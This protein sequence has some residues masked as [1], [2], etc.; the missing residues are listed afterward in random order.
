M[1]NRWVVTAAHCVASSKIYS[2][3]I[4]RH[5]RTRVKLKVA[6]VSAHKVEKMILDFRVYLFTT[7]I[8]GYNDVIRQF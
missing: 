6:K 3:Y 4:V 5:T 2:I 1:A 8:C 7:V